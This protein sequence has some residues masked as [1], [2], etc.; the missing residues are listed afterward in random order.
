MQLWH[1]NYD[2]HLIQMLFVCTRIKLP[3]KCKRQPERYG[4][5]S[6]TRQI[7]FVHVCLITSL[8]RNGNNPSLRHVNREL[9]GEG[10]RN[11]VCIEVRFARSIALYTEAPRLPWSSC[12]RTRSRHDKMQMSQRFFLR[13]TWKNIT[14]QHDVLMQRELPQKQ[15]N[16]KRYV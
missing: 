5:P 9:I 8:L 1:N 14:T 2:L 10:K 3:K 15:E 12:Y 16:E 11:C 4:K 7:V 13:E 6:F